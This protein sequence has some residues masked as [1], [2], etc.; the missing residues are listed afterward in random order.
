MSENLMKMESRLR[1]NDEVVSRNPSAPLRHSHVR[2][3]PSVPVRP[4]HAGSKPSVPLRH[5]RVGG[6]PSVNN[7]NREWKI[8][9]I[10]KE[11]KKWIDIC[12]KI[13]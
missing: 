5:S 4:S 3:N 1:G 2:G 11:N 9:L 8:N 7:W 6:K 13:Q 12:P 10:E